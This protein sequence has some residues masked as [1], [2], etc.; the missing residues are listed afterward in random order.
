MVLSKKI[1]QGYEQQVDLQLMNQGGLPLIVQTVRLW[2]DFKLEK[3][4]MHPWSFSWN[5]RE[6]QNFQKIRVDGHDVAMISLPLSETSNAGY[7]HGDF[8]RAVN[9]Y[10]EKHVNSLLVNNTSP[11]WYVSAMKIGLRSDEKDHPLDDGEIRLRVNPFGVLNGELRLSATVYLRGILYIEWWDEK[12]KTQNS[13]EDVIVQLE[14]RSEPLA[15][16]EGPI[17]KKFP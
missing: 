12:F 2:H 9:D 1:N 11:S 6:G 4:D 13:N 17:F 5:A 14:F 15:V 8:I 3:S 7:S 10:A 16:P